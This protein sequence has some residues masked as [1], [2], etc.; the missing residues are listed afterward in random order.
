MPFLQVEQIVSISGSGCRLDLY[1]Q[2]PIIDADQTVKRH[3]FRHRKDCQTVPNEQ[4]ID[5]KLA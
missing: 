4:A 3:T 1:F 5:K 2:V